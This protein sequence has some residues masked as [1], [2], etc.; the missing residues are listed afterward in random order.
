MKSNTCGNP[1]DSR[2]DWA[3]QALLA[4][5]SRNPDYRAPRRIQGQKAHKMTNHPH[6][7]K[8]RERVTEIPAKVALIKLHAQNEIMV[9]PRSVSAQDRLFLVSVI[10]QLWAEN[11]QEKPQC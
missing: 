5:S 7:S 3:T 10:E 2:L 6:R 9:N 8:R 1:A 11:E 4:L